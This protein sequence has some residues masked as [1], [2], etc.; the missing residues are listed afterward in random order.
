MVKYDDFMKDPDK[1]IDE[2]YD[3]TNAEIDDLVHWKDIS[4][5]YKKIYYVS[6]SRDNSCAGIFIC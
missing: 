5:E 2:A 4:H 6:L 3:K 1:Y